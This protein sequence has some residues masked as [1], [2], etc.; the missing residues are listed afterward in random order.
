MPLPNVTRALKKKLSQAMASEQAMQLLADPRVQKAMMN[1]FTAQMK[2]REHWK[3]GLNAVARQLHL[4]T[5]EEVRDMKRTIN[6]LE[7]QLK[8]AQAKS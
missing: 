6:R 3:N 1:A 8:K 5:R 4:A 7:K 2:A